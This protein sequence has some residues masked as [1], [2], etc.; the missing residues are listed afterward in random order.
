MVNKQYQLVAI[1][2][3]EIYFSLEEKCVAFEEKLMKFVGRINSSK[4]KISS[5]FTLRRKKGCHLKTK[6]AKTIIRE[7]WFL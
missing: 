7:C 4:T 2:V 6:N 5:W 3:L 1:V